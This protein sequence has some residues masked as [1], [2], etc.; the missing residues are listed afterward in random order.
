[1]TIRKPKGITFQFDLIFLRLIIQK[2]IQ[3][4]SN[5]SSGSLLYVC[6]SFYGVAG[7]FLRPSILYE[8]L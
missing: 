1:M 2:L 6:V 4:R 5:N 3:E 8:T 7:G